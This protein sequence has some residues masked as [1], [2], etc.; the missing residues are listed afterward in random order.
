[1][2]KQSAVLLTGIYGSG[3]STVV[4]DM[5]ALLQRR[6]RSFGLL[7]VDWLGW[8]DV[9]GEPEV[10]QRVTLSN[11]SSIC[12]AYL[13]VGVRHLVVAWSIR[14]QAHLDATRAAVGVPTTVVRLEVDEATVRARLGVDPTEERRTD[15]LAVALAWLSHG[16]GVGLED[17]VVSGTSPVREISNEICQHL[18][19][20]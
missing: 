11:L 18:G 6:G 14:D 1:M 9:P 2:S 19:W 12:S 10:N 3:K 13:D 8:F 16:Q 5:G 17:L 4:A 7:D 20:G 15:D